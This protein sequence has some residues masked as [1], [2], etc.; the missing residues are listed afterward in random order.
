MQWD[1][2]ECRERNGVISFYQGLFS[3]MERNSISFFTSARMFTSA[4][5]P[6]STYIVNVNAVGGPAGTVAIETPTAGGKL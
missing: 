4:L 3:S 5:L 2:V 6:R 1:E